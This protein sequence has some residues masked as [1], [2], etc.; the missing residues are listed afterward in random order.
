MDGLF[1]GYASLFGVPDLGRDVVAPGAFA[2][3]LA[4]RGAEGVRMLWQH[5]P[6]EP[7]GRWLSLREDAR[8]LRVEGRL[9]RAVQRAREL[10]ALLNEGALDGLSI[11]FRTIRARP[12]RGG[13]RRLEA[14]DLWEISLV[15]FPLQAGARIAAPARAG[16]APAALVR[17]LHALARRMAPSRRAATPSTRPGSRPAAILPA[18]SARFA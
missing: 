5:D 6:A 13:T 15:T 3:S 8:G 17:D 12:E 18:R 7:V 16:T 2:A 9:N 11:G 10:D 14:V 1:T 4:A